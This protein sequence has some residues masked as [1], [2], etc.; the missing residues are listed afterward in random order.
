MFKALTKQEKLILFFVSH[1]LPN[2]EIAEAMGLS[3]NTVKVHK[4]NLYKKLNLV[5]L[6]KVEA[7]K[8]LQ[9]FASDNEDLFANLF[10]GEDNA[11]D[12]RESPLA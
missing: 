4:H 9:Q 11:N 7:R 5:G 8:N 3:K 6:G 2:K 1:D 10:P 12:Q